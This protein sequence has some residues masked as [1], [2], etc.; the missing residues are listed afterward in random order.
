MPKKI[1]ADTTSQL[2]VFAGLIQDGNLSI[3]DS[4]P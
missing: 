1:I 2:F 3:F 4:Y